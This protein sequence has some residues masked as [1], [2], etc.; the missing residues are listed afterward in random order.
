MAV[1]ALLG[2]GAACLLTSDHG[3]ACGDGYVDREVG[4]DCDPALASSFEGMCDD[5]EK[6]GARALCNDDCEV[7]CRFCGDGVLEG[8]EGEE[9]EECDPS[10]FDEECDGVGFLACVD[11]KVDRSNCDTCRNGKVDP[12]EDC[13]FDPNLDDITDP[14]QIQCIGLPVP[15]N[16]DKTYTAGR[17]GCTNECEWDLSTCSLCGDGTI[18]GAIVDPVTSIEIRPAEVCDGPPPPDVAEEVC[19]PYCPSLYEG[20]VCDVVCA[21]GCLQVEVV[22]PD[23]PRCCLL[24]GA[25]KPPGA[26]P[27][28]CE[29][30]DPDAPDDTDTCSLILAPDG[31]DPI[32]PFSS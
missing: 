4:E 29:L 13:D 8:K 30:P 19:A 26:P 15:N 5:P 25:P 32:C 12:G 23:N 14:E 10:S 18:D 7:E 1:A 27:C 2:H 20:V 11:C 9:G 28:C 24:D 22:D 21:D 6:P 16:P 31:A 17:R 3:K